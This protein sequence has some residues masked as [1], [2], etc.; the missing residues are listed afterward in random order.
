M[1]FN[2]TNT[3]VA[4]GL[5][6]FLLA[7]TSYGQG[8]LGMQLF[9]PADV[10]TFGGDI[11]PNEGYFFQFDGLWWSV[12]GPD[13][14]P[15][16][17]P[18]LT[19][20]VFYTPTDSRLQSNTLDT[21]DVKGYFTY[22]ARYEFG[23]VENRNGW[24][25]SIFQ[26][27]DQEEDLPYDSA[28]VV[29]KDLSDP[30]LLRGPVPVPNSDPPVSATRELP[31]T[32]YDVLMTHS[33]STWG[34]ELMY[35]HRNLTRHGGGT[36]EWFI[37][38][39][40]LY[41][42]DDFAIYTG[43]SPEGVTATSFLGGSTWHSSAENNIIGGEIGLRWFKKQGRWMFSTEGRFLA[44]L[45]C[46][47]IHVQSNLGPNLNPGGGA[48]FNPETMGPN[49]T[50]RQEY[51]REFSPAIELRLE[52]RYQITRAISFH[53]GWTGLWVDNIARGSAV[54][55]YSVPSMGVDMSG[56]KQSIFMNGLTLGV[57]INR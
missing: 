38:P 14:S 1:P 57:D 23:R 28:D 30:H 24:F 37:G 49:N 47:N 51:A 52:G 8:P 35:L 50:T 21:S 4:V 32:V 41:L 10:S 40:F 55:D 45:N 31:V 7:A 29:F 43:S 11:E 46:Q 15:V 44:G 13:A 26:L 56:N 2:R 5:F 20:T 36:F 3:G 48:D 53:A 39:R 33:L 17:A 12:S 16:G 27:R 18:G 22:G 9:A 6:V 34:V 42:E 19:R 25:C 54:I